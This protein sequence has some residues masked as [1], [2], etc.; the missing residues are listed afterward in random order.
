MATLEQFLGEIG[1]GSLSTALEWPLKDA[2]PD[3]DES[4]GP[5]DKLYRR[6][7]QEVE[8]NDD[9]TLALLRD[10]WDDFSQQ[11]QTGDQLV[12][13]LKDEETELASLENEMDGPDA[14]LPGLVSH[15]ETQQAL[16]AAHLVTTTSVAL[17]STL[18]A[19]NT[20]VAALSAATGSGDLVAAVQAQ[21]SVT[22]A[23]EV[24][25]EEWIE[26]TDV[27]KSLIRWAGEEESRLEAALQG[28]VESCFQ[29]EPASAENGRV[30]RLVLCERVAA[31]P[32]GPE[33]PVEALLRGLED[34]AAITGRKDQSDAL[35]VRMAKQILRH[36][37]APF[38]EANGLPKSTTADKPRLDFVV[39]SP[40]GS[41]GG[42][43]SISLQ[44]AEAGEGAEAIKGLSAFLDFVTKRSSLFPASPSDSTSKHAAVFTA[45]LTPSLQSH[46]ISSHLTPSLPI[47][48]DSLD[49]YMAILATA[50][51][52]EADFLA[53][54]HLFAFL[55][56]SLRREGHEVEEQ[57]VIRS[58]ATRVPHHWA[59]HVGDSALARIRT[60]VKSWDWGVG[61]MVEVEVKEEEEML[62]LLLGL[63][64]VD[65]ED[66]AAVAAAAAGDPS[67]LDLRNGKPTSATEPS[68]DGKRRLPRELALQT[69]P[70]SA[71][72]EMTVEEAL[73]P[74]VRRTRTPSPPRQP[75]VVVDSVAAAAPADEQ[76][77]ESETGQ[78]G[79]PASPPPRGVTKRGKLGAA[80]IG[81]V[82][83]PP[84]RSPSPPPQ[85]RE[86]YTTASDPVTSNPN[87]DDGVSEEVDLPEEAVSPPPTAEQVAPPPPPAN[88]VAPVQIQFLAQDE[89][90]VP[91]PMEDEVFSPF[92]APATTAVGIETTADAAPEEDV[93]RPHEY[94]AQVREEIGEDA[95]E[96]R[97]KSPLAREDLEEQSAAS[98]AADAAPQS[99]PQAVP[100][101]D[102]S[103]HTV[104]ASSHVSD[105]D[106]HALAVKEESLEPELPPAATMD[107]I[108]PAPVHHDI[109]SEKIQTDEKS[110]VLADGVETA[111]W[112]PTPDRTEG[113]A[114]AEADLQ[115]SWQPVPIET[116]DFDDYNDLLDIEDVGPPSRGPELEAPHNAG[117]RDGDASLLFADSTETAPD[118]VASSFDEVM[119]ESAALMVDSQ[120]AISAPDAALGSELNAYVPFDDDPYADDSFADLAEG[121]D[122]PAP[123]RDDFFSPPDENGAVPA[124]AAASAVQDPADPYAPPPPPP[125]PPREEMREEY[126]PVAAAMPPQPIQPAP[127]ASSRYAPPPP[128]TS[129][130]SPPQPPSLSQVSAA[131]SMA[132]PPPPRASNAYAPPVRAKPPKRRIVGFG[133]VGTVDAAPATESAGPVHPLPVNESPLPPISS[134][135]TQEAA[136]SPRTAIAPLRS[137]FT[138]LSRPARSGTPPR[139][140]GP[141]LNHI[142]QRFVSPPP[143]TL[144][145]YVPMSIPPTAPVASSYLPA[146]DPLF[147]DLLGGV[148]SRPKPATPNYFSPDRRGPPSNSPAPP[149]NAHAAGFP[150]ASAPQQPAYGAY[151]AAQNPYAYSA[152]P[153]GGQQYGFSQYGAHSQHMQPAMRMRGGFSW[154]TVPEDAVGDA[155]DVLR[156]RGGADLGDM[157]DDGNHSADDWGFGSD[158]VASG[159]IE[160]DAW[161]FDDE[162][163]APAVIPSPAGPDATRAPAPTTSAAYKPPAPSSPTRVHTSTMSNASAVPDAP[164]T[165]SVIR[166]RPTSLVYSP[167][168]AP[169]PRR[170]LD[171]AVAE[172]ISPD[173]DE[174][175]IGDDAWGFDEEEVEGAIPAVPEPAMD[176]AAG[177]QSRDTPAPETRDR[178]DD[179]DEEPN[180][181]E[182]SAHPDASHAQAGADAAS[183]AESRPE[184]DDWGFG[185]EGDAI[186]EDSETFFGPEGDAIPEGSETFAA[187]SEGVVDSLD[188]PPRSEDDATSNSP[189]STSPPP[190]GI[191]SSGYEPER[192]EDKP[193]SA[194]KPSTRQTEPEPLPTMSP[195]L[196]A[197]PISPHGAH[198]ITTESPH[199]DARDLEGELD[200]AA[201]E[202]V[203]EEAPDEPADAA[204][205]T[206]SPFVPSSTAETERMNA[207]MPTDQISAAERERDVSA[208]DRHQP[209]VS[210][211]AASSGTPS[212]AD[213]YTHD[214]EPAETDVLAGVAPPKPAKPDSL[215]TD[216]AGTE[217]A[218]EL[219]AL[220][221]PA[222]QLH[223][224]FPYDATPP[225]ADTPLIAQPL[226]HS[227]DFQP[228][229]I[230]G[231]QESHL[232]AY[233]ASQLED[234]GLLVEDDEH[235]DDP[236]S[237][238]ND[239]A[240]VAE[241][242][243]SAPR[244]DLAALGNFTGDRTEAEQLEH[245]LPLEDSF[246]EPRAGPAQT[247]QPHDFHQADAPP[248]TTS[249][250]FDD[251]A[252]FNSSERV[253]KSQQ[254]AWEPFEEPSG[255]PESTPP[256][257]DGYDRRAERDRDGFSAE[258]SEVPEV[259]RRSSV[260]GGDVDAAG[261]RDAPPESE[262][263][264]STSAEGSGVMVREADMSSPEL[265]DQNGEWEHQAVGAEILEVKDETSEGVQ[266][267][268][269]ESVVQH[270]ELRPA[271]HDESAVQHESQ[272]LIVADDVVIQPGV[273]LPA[274]DAHPQQRTF[275]PPV[276]ALPE[277][278]EGVEWDLD[279]DDADV[280]AEVLAEPAHEAEL[281]PPPIPDESTVQ[282]IAERSTAEGA[283]TARE[284]LPASTAQPQEHTFSLP[285][286][287]VPHQSTQRSSSDAVETFEAPVTAEPEGDDGADWD[288]ADGAAVTGAELLGEP[289]FETELAPSPVPNESTVQHIAERATIGDA[290]AEPEPLPTAAVQ[291]PEHIFSPPLSAL[292]K[293]SPQEQRS[294]FAETQASP[295]G[296][297][298]AGD[299][300]AEW[301][302]DDDDDVAVLGAESLAEP[303]FETD[304]APSPIPDE[305][306]VQHVTECVPVADTESTKEPLPVST[307]QPHE[308]TFTPSMSALPAPPV[309]EQPAHSAEPP[310]SSTPDHAPPSP[311]LSTAED[312]VRSVDSARDGSDR[313]GASLKVQHT[314]DD[315]EAPPPVSGER[316]EA[317]VD[318]PWDLDPLAPEATVADF[319]AGLLPPDAVPAAASNQ[320]GKFAEGSETLLPATSSVA[321]RTEEAQ[322]P[323]PSMPGPVVESEQE[324]TGATVPVPSL[325]LPSAE[326]PA[327]SPKARAVD[328]TPGRSESGAV[329]DGADETWD[330]NDDEP[331]A[332]ETRAEAV[333]ASSPS[334]SADS[335]L[336]P[337]AQPAVPSADEVS[338]TPA[339]RREKMMVSRQSR[340]IIGIAEQ[341]LKEAFEVSSSGFSLPQFSAAFEPLLRTF[342]SIL[343]LYRATASVH[344]S[345]LLASVPAIAMQFANDAEWIGREADRV[346][347]SVPSDKAARV[348]K[349]QVREI[350]L[351]IQSTRQLGRDT[352]QKQISIQQAALMESLDEA[353][354]FLG[355]LNENRYAACERALQQVI[356]TLQRLAL[357]WKPIMTSTALYTTL[358]GL[359]NEVLLRVL[360]EIEEQTDISEE[361]S[362]RLNKLS[363][364]L[365]DL[366]GLFDGSETNVGREVPIWYK[367]SFLSELLEASMADFMF[368]FD[369]R[370]LLDFTPQELVRLLRALFA[371][372]PQRDAAVKRVLQGHPDAPA[373]EEESS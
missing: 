160:E 325:P 98:D 295:A 339:V 164:S 193:S 1:A 85:S 234:A 302:L 237:L 298:T 38:L 80:R 157:D 356:H 64:L 248:P 11:L 29:V 24:G 168:L 63:G 255:H 183:L 53:T 291:P 41:Q 214:G 120:A 171:I 296:A 59:R 244:D 242:E 217:P 264:P 308:H 23:V 238:G 208:A 322:S 201:V 309:P 97:A 192:S 300:E 230:A 90:I 141:I 54:H 220:S 202:P 241:A 269:R 343:S 151:P 277:G 112:T 48:I 344:N 71:K 195:G 148:T 370:F 280:G 123:T 281:A 297:L 135:Q 166:S 312:F 126:V 101:E 20:T 103:V 216:G 263:S 163:N 145:P 33:I 92:E 188:A 55:P 110:S 207:S 70:K 304:T 115:S 39:S 290:L 142:Q 65:P 177:P 165:P 352:R 106:S 333:P 323:S 258:P 132:A 224:D 205:G 93:V 137:A 161:G 2:A 287:A 26:E 286:A 16:A 210:T 30:A 366:E 52:F 239:D 118:F 81:P 72:R 317:D 369:N 365:H 156:L 240:N 348:P 69:V 219:S 119:V 327:E 138:N 353:G 47:S 42:V 268:E 288:F 172:S 340:E 247:T 140:D 346:W 211:D 213:E 104:A 349:S 319:A 139:Q 218:R 51:A 186:P 198:P 197:A 162:E 180:R 303:A 40:D 362:I 351:A 363:K 206:R 236:W 321:A 361:E 129:V 150:N 284:P 144:N 294:N 221:A 152:P 194:D 25:A 347:H 373:D 82:D 46:V 360:D 372:S 331:P 181:T 175:D 62:G 127:P 371:D 318:D 96:Q 43:H 306:T 10:Q 125:P 21:R 191:T 83:V 231:A 215:A 35:L 45:H 307:V 249:P 5:A 283:F 87:G 18:L 173:D 337:S 170:S 190:K 100:A 130:A 359:V 155:G 17:L 143:S 266:V 223:D 262:V 169:P 305:S 324:A 355:T 315:I 89:I 109:E 232:V 84:P 313:E 342:V 113:V 289:A 13:Q 261:S 79:A 184:V 209:E 117:T 235:V 116:T 257:A 36:F 182:T 275:T 253:Q 94:R 225:P 243:D 99:T 332:T 176:E 153:Q 74:K 246:L 274:Q 310:V 228:G 95:D 357:V 367:F 330:W 187:P 301:N 199:D 250:D 49:Q 203:R 368:L 7:Q 15:L 34:L 28:A 167:S 159:D 86:D 272:R 338:S 354:G 6:I 61:E 56:P 77:V 345:N 311:A 200:E 111:P 108:S 67:Q 60:S 212:A 285:T 121:E 364:M 267:A 114:E 44:P 254:P 3:H 131:T 336:P 252:D 88:A 178:M 102:L 22:R 19:F 328:T 78:G 32:N 334:K 341:V 251:F 270:E 147:A 233:A 245:D 299:D 282:H 9:K 27:W 136:V 124:D 105:Q 326:V 278:D 149:H 31:A 320:A 107:Y 158:P 271:P 260:E 335:S 276:T 91:Q 134:T 58:W 189:P 57:R 293:R 68:F 179:T 12:R 314:P 50:T 37:I 73:Q 256:S 279:H 14:F 259:L 76:H 292:P 185:L 316:G 133:E 154:D 227:D 226:P 75:P 66:E 8:H 350:E 265:V 196:V 4:H 122:Y 273:V 329:E 204:P 174:E 358:G 146:N 128:A 222:E 229:T